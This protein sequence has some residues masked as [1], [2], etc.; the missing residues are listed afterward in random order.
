MP[1]GR[2]AP[3]RERR[4]PSNRHTGKTQSLDYVRTA[5]Q[6]LG[7]TPTYGIRSADTTY[8]PRTTTSGFG[9]RGSANRGLFFARPLRTAACAGHS[10]RMCWYVISASV[11]GGAAPVTYRRCYERR[12]RGGH[13]SGGALPPISRDDSYLLLNISP[14]L[15]GTGYRTEIFQRA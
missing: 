9:R 15:N 8:R 14:R 13:G 6:P 1:C 12:D 3:H 7:R 5:Q 11:A 4:L 2:P 10:V